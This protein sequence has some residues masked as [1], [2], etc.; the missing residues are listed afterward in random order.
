MEINSQFDGGNIKCISC[1]SPQTIHLEIEADRNTSTLQWF[2]FRL[3][4]AKDQAC[5]IQITNAGKASYL[6]GWENYQA[7]ASYC[8]QTWTRIETSYHDGILTLSLTP[9]ENSIYIAYFAPYSLEQQADFLAQIQRSPL[10]DVNILGKTLDGRPIECVTVQST[11]D[12]SNQKQKK[13]LWLIARQHAGETM[14]SW[15]ME[16]FLT[17]LTDKTDP[18]SQRLLSQANFYIIPNMN[19]DGSFRGHLRTNANGLDLNRQWQ[20][21]TAET[22]PE[23]YYVRNAMQKTGID[24]CLDVHGDEALPHNFIAGAEGI[25]GWNKHL[26]TLTETY[27]EALMQANPDFQT[28]FGYPIDAP[29]TANLTVCSNYIAETF[30][31]LAMTLEMPFK[32]TSHFTDPLHGWSPD[33]SKKLG[34]TNLDAIYAIIEAL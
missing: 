3:T 28:E 4:G 19:P 6:D 7:L 12:N 14:A 31:C 27:K 15:W 10:T 32:D 34:A 30:S 1:T 23:V 13:N 11:T 33:R 17:R 16:G 5:R 22:S 9:T 29:G 25:P 21:T 20:D 26:E 18:I 8:R 2:Y 24:F